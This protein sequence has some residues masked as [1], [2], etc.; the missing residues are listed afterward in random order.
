M[1]FKAKAK[2]TNL[3]PRGASRTHH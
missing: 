1:A 2:T 3:C